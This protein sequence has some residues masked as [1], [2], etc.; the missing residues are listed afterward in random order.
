MTKLKVDFKQ[1]N[2]SELRFLRKSTP[3]AVVY[4]IL[5]ILT[6]GLLTL[7][8]YWFENFQLWIYQTIEHE[9]LATH[10]QV[11]NRKGESQ[12]ICELKRERLRLFPHQPP[13]DYVYFRYTYNFYYI[14][15]KHHSLKHLRNKLYQKLRKNPQL[16]ESYKKANADEIAAEIEQTFGLNVIDIKPE[17][18]IHLILKE[19]FAPFTM[20]QI[21]SIIVWFFDNYTAYAILILVMMTGSIFMNIHETIVQTRKIR[22]MTYFDAPVTVIRKRG[23]DSVDSERTVTSKNSNQRSGKG[24]VKAMDY[25]YQPLEDDV[26]AIEMTVQHNSKIVNSKLKLQMVSSLHLQ[27]G[28]LMFINA[29]EVVPADFL[30]IE[31]KCLIDEAIL[32]GETFPILKGPFDSSL[33]LS[34]HNVVYAGTKCLSSNGA[35]GIVINTGFYTKKGE[36][37]R[38]LL[39]AENNE[40]EF[41]RD[42]Y[43]FV[44]YIFLGTL[45]IFLWF[46]KFVAFGSYHP[47][48]NIRNLVLKGL[49]MFTTSIPPALPL[50]LTIG[51]QLANQRLSE[52]QIYTTVLEKI[53]QAG[54]ISVMCFDKTG[55]LTESSLH[56][57]GILPCVYPKSQSEAESIVSFDENG[58]AVHSFSFKRIYK[59]FGNLLKDKTVNNSD[60]NLIAEAISS[61]HSLS[62][63][64]GEVVGDQIEVQLFGETGFNLQ[65][66]GE[67]VLITGKLG[68]GSKR[69]E[70]ELDTAEQKM[71]LR[72]IKKIEFSSE[73]KRMSVVCRN[74]KDSSLKVF[75]KG[76][77]ETIKQLCL[78]S[79]IPA[80]FDK[81]LEEYSK[82]GLRI[83]GLAYKQIDNE[84]QSSK[85]LES[86]LTFIGFLFFQNS[87]KSTTRDTI[88][89]LSRCRVNTKMITGDNLLTA[90]SVA[91]DS[92]IL[93]QSKRLFLAHVEKGDVLWN[94]VESESTRKSLRRSIF[95]HELS[96]FIDIPPVAS[97]LDISAFHETHKHGKNF[98]QY[99]MNEC[100]KGQAAIGMTG[101]AFDALLLNRDLHNPIYRILLENSI[102]FARTDPEQKAQIVATFQQMLKISY[103]DSWLVGFCGD[104]ANDCAALR[105]A[106]VGLSIAQ[107]E[108]SIAAPFNT[109]ITNI[110]PTIDLV[111]EGKSSLETAL[112]NF[113]YIL[114]YSVIQFY[115]VIACYSSAYEFSNGHYYYMD[116]FCF[117]PL[118][119]FLSNNA[120]SD[121]LNKY[122]PKASLLNFEVLVGIVGHLFI[123]G[124]GMGSLAY[125][126]KYYPE[127][128]YVI[129]STTKFE[130]VPDNYYFAQPNAYFYFASL[131]Y[132]ITVLIF[133]K[134]Y[135]FKQ[136]F[137][138]NWALTF[139]SLMS[140]FVTLIIAYIN[141]LPVGFDIQHLVNSLFR[142]IF[143]EHNYVHLYVF[144]AIIF[145]FLSWLHEKYL[146]GIL[147]N[148]HQRRVN[149]RRQ[150]QWESQLF[151]SEKDL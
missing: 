96:G 53:N 6:L 122:F 70:K 151:K 15:K 87:L 49:E 32:T 84:N 116:L 47:Y 55:T 13:K 147:V 78:P 74:E 38:S 125:I 102:V 128:L 61:C 94:E 144:W 66:T 11:L 35:L 131:L 101:E 54:R 46:V 119:V 82:Q 26:E 10:V 65:E 105:Q 20:F 114:F 8:F 118:S 56:L 5:S 22:E 79:T 52:K 42:S 103:D 9:E 48:Y 85:S 134:G 107:T 51:L 126:A 146:L 75:T 1:D 86:G 30:L 36:M 130:I 43:I 29:N 2:I 63:L 149:V 72:I 139:Y 108:A 64:N 60:K 120:A 7:L 34:S 25:K 113:K 127:N 112:Q 17:P 57:F 28:D 44:G 83:L 95:G 69:S 76:A 19:L 132:S 16:V 109:T 100:Q 129:E 68:Q 91:T 41:K 37:V 141:F 121:K 71:T 59:S 89:T 98:L 133:S 148:W 110:A 93:S 45:I 18:V 3:R 50:C 97:G 39:F 81:I 4:L 12:A 115:G 117:L 90:I 104:G 62:V 88:K 31:G 124:I 58:P 143:Y 80:G 136:P 123:A 92:G 21:A 135:P 40:F 77:P 24:S 106:D 111:R 137:Y 73:R 23:E 145:A 138:K 27:I 14:S 33:P 67:T 150:K 140:L 142:Q 99:L